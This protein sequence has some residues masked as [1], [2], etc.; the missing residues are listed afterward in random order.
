MTVKSNSLIYLRMYQEPNTKRLTLS[1]ILLKK[2]NYQQTS[3]KTTHESKESISEQK[4]FNEQN[5]MITFACK[6]YIRYEVI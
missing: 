1:L 5:L 2:G 6:A 3:R 4:S